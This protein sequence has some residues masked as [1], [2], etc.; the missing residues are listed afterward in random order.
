MVVH[1]E[2]FNVDT[3]SLSVVR[4]TSTLGSNIRLTMRH[5]QKLALLRD[6][7]FKDTNHAMMSDA[8]ERDILE[9]VD[10]SR[11]EKTVD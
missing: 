4:Q 9:N 7:Y 1:V 6:P 3:E 11:L 2:I 8:D 10:S 5:S